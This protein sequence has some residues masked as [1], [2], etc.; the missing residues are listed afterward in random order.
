MIIWLQGQMV[1]TLQRSGAAGALRPRAGGPHPGI[2]EKRQREAI[3]PFYAAL[4]RF[5]TEFFWRK[6]A[7]RQPGRLRYVPGDIP[8]VT[9]YFR[10]FPLILGGGWCRFASEFFWRGK[11]GGLQNARQ[12]VGALPDRKRLS[13]AKR[14]ANFIAFCRLLS[15]SVAFCRLGGACPRVSSFQSGRAGR[16]APRHAG[17]PHNAA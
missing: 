11:A 2:G 5:A 6:C 13:G 7:T 14:R 1:T 10:L 12:T 16:P 15:A 3:P 4:C 9:A 8:L 17:K